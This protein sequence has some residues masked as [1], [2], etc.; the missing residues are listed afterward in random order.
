MGRRG[1]GLER[2]WRT[3]PLEEGH[4]QGMRV[5]LSLAIRFG[6]ESQLQTAKTRRQIRFKSKL[7]S[8]RRFRAFEF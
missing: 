3:L 5:A 4:V 8:R 7:A 2:G 6:S 1:E